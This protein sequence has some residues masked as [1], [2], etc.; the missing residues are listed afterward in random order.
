[1]LA[2]T[3]WKSSLAVISLCVSAEL[4]RREGG[5]VT[6]RGCGTIRVVAG[7]RR[8]SSLQY[9]GAE[10]VRSG[11]QLRT[12]L[13]SVHVR[14]TSHFTLSNTAKLWIYNVFKACDCS[15]GWW[16]CAL[17]QGPVSCAGEEVA[18]WEPA[19]CFIWGCAASGAGP[20]QGSARAADS[21]HSNGRMPWRTAERP[22]QVRL[23]FYDVTL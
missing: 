19:V 17:F 5:F 12:G 11:C 7:S 15:D 8:S 18:G 3:I 21:G 16:V 9:R 13:Q 20:N 6:F 22:S 14:R 23:H 4:F 2:Y 1:M 10:A